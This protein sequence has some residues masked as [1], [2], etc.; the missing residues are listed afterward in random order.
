MKTT[1][2]VFSYLTM[3]FIQ[4]IEIIIRKIENDNQNPTREKKILVRPNVI[5]D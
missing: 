2:F 5:M 3:E 4:L 1:Y